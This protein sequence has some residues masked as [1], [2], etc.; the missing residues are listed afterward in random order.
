MK[1]LVFFVCLTIY[2]SI[3]PAASQKQPLDRA[4]Q[5]DLT[6][7]QVIAKTCK[8][9]EGRSNPSV[10]P[11][12]LVGKVLCGYQ[13]WFTCPGDGSGKGW[14]HWEE[15]VDDAEREKGKIG[16]F[17]PGHCSIDLW[18]DVSELDEDEKYPT[19]FKH[20]DSSVAR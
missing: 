2:T 7:D 19:E 5:F 12:T 15:H 4:E 18:P 10:D 20:A 6:L 17:K 11:E 8:P 13:G 3:L 14:Y 9:Y 1:R 16:E